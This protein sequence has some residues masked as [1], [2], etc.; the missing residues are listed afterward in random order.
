MTTTPQHLTRPE[1]RVAYTVTGSGPLVVTAP[2]MGDL[3]DVYRDV[4]PALVAAGYRVASTDL[5]GHGA[6]DTTFTTH[7]VRETA[8]DLLALVEDLGSPAVLV[9]HSM[10]ADSAAWAA[11]QGGDLVAGV[12]LISPHLQAP[13]AGRLARLQVSALLRR[14]W[15]AAAW[16]AFYRSLHPGRRAPWFDEHL[17]AIR[18]ALRDPGRMS[19]FG[20][21]ARSLIAGH[22]H[23]P[24]DEVTVP[25]LVLHGELDPELKDPAAELELATSLLVAADVTTRLVPESGHYPHSQR[26]D[27]VVPALLDLLS[28]VARRSSAWNRAG[29]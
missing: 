4:V 26:P 10:S 7:G 24:L 23:L 11:I 15:G 27:V 17:T 2:G 8:G 14:P 25:T 9:G 28:V 20:A 6:S 22:P 5:R 13:P 3:G 16:A 29:A 12:V 18:T 21:L 19:S 1:G